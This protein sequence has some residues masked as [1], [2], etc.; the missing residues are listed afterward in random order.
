MWSRY[1]ELEKSVGES[2]RCRTIFEQ[3]IS[4]KVAVFE[5]AKGNEKSMSN[6]DAKRR[7]K[8]KRMRTDENGN[9][10]GWEEVFDY[11][12]PDDQ[13]APS[14]NLK[15]LEIAAKWKQ[16]QAQQQDD[17]DLE[18]NSDDE[19]GQTIKKRIP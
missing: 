8:K 17:D 14:S 2:E 4:L 11:Y 6:V 15:I 19:W 18:S 9:E 13:D 12:F 1:A 3:V 16:L 10:L 5:K 7:I